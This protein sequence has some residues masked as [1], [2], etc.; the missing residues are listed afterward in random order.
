MT[1]NKIFGRWAVLGAAGV[2][3]FCFGADAQAAVLY[4]TPE[5][6]S[7]QPGETAVLD[8]RIDPEGECINAAEINIGFPK[9]LLEAIDVSRGQSILTL[10]VEPPAIKQEFGLI[11]FTGGVPG[12]YCGRVPGDSALTNIL[13][14]LVFR[15][16]GSL[17]DLPA[18]A[19][20]SILESSKVL[21]N[22]GLGTEARLTRN[23]SNLHISY[24][25]KPQENAWTKIIVNDKTA[26]EPFVIQ[27]QRDATAFGG[28]HFAVFS[29]VDKQ[30][31]IDRYEISETKSAKT[32][33]KDVKWNAAKS[34]YVLLDQTLMNMIRVKAI[35]KAGNERIAEFAPTKSGWRPWWLF[36]VLGLVSVFVAI[37]FKVI[38][39][40]W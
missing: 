22:D 2:A 34:P 39:L 4:F 16:P 37:V 1:N 11:S 23:D 5:S 28:K 35:D 30:S 8:L 6:A 10:W 25:G 13:A 24:T 38:P 14:Q 27:V 17:K 20:V 18:E 12:G 36:W 19:K 31:G 29:A 7:F 3:L 32:P 21:L 15:F 33:M 26:P 40:S 9:D